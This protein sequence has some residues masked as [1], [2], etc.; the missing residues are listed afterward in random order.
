MTDNTPMIERIRKLFAK[1]ESTTSEHEKDALLSK[2]YDLLAK[3]GIAETLARGDGAAEAASVGTWTFTAKA[4]YKLDQILLINTVAKA[5]HCDAIKTEKDTLV[6]YGAKRHLDRVAM[7]GGFLVAYM[8]GNLGKVRS[9]YSHVSTVTYRKSAM[10]G[11]IQTVG[12]R[13]KASER[14]AVNESDDKASTEIVLVSDKD[15]AAAALRDDF[16]NVVVGGQTRRSSAGYGAG[17]RAGNSVDLGGSKAMGGS[18][19]AISA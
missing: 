4:S 9:P 14:N 1:A 15:K 6:V 2:A 7:L 8:I 18:R 10:H 17:Q 13:L 12:E 5:L 16:P 11:F 3:H 19:R